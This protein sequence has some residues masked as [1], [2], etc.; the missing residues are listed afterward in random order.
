[1]VV[2]GVPAKIVLRS[3]RDTATLTNTGPKPPSTRQAG[4]SAPRKGGKK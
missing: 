2:D 3:G 4:L 1:V